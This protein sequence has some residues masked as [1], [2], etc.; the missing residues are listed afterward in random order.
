MEEA[1][2][3]IGLPQSNL[4]PEDE[5]IDLLLNAAEVEQGL[6][7]QYLYAAYSATDSV[8]SGI[9]KEIAI[10]EMGHLLTVQNILLACGQL[11]YLGRDDGTNQRH[12]HPF[13]FRLEPAGR[14]ALAKYAAAEMPDPEALWF[15]LSLKPDLPSIL[16]EAAVSAEGDVAIHRVGLLYMKIYWLLREDDKPLADPSKEPWSGFPVEQV[17]ATSGMAGKHVKEGFLQDHTASEAVASHWRGTHI[18]MIIDLISDKETARKAIAEISAQGEGF[19]ATPDGH[20]E[21]F[22]A[23]WRRARSASDPIAGNT[24]VDPWYA[25]SNV[26]EVKLESEIS[27][28]IGIKF[29]QIAD[30]AYELCLL[31][32]A[33]SLLIPTAASADDRRK[34]AR[35]A[36]NCMRDGIGTCAVNLR[37]L[38]L[39]AG[40]DGSAVRCGLPFSVPPPI[41]M[42]NAA[43]LKQRA[44]SV[45]ALVVAAAASIDV[46]SGATTRQIEDAAGIRARFETAIGPAI[47]AVPIALL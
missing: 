34:A 5:L 46:T 37:D 36:I 22:A 2:T 15:P 26:P 25:G 19:A 32:I 14:A 29:A 16:A 41:D 40:G 43:A 3:T 17:A 8:I 23:A 31:V 13:K 42:A 44:K 9:V 39:M 12:F 6:A 33:L 1:L 47:E 11:P 35:T 10:E 7:L 18:N 45:V 4:A 38:P 20:F 30:G 21:R 28:P 24:A 27:N